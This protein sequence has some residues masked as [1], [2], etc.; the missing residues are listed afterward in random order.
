MARKKFFLI[1]S[2][3]PPAADVVREDFLIIPENDEINVDVGA[4]C[5]FR[6]EKSKDKFEE[7]AGKIIQ[8][9]MEVSDPLAASVHEPFCNI[10]F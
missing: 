9:G 8:T 10:S 3:N 4:E 7:V 2:S 5:S 1:Y 6:W